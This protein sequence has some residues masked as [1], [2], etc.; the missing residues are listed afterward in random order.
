MAKSPPKKHTPPKTG[1]AGE[2]IV[3]D[4]LRK[5]GAKK[6]RV[7]TKQPGATD[8][9]AETPAGRKRI[10]VKT[11]VTPNKPKEPSTQEK[12]EIKKAAKQEGATAE[13]AKVTVNKNLQKVKVKRRKLD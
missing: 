2:Q 13:I 5:Q 6:I 3:A 11:A 10:Q 12:K 1:K 7:D 9:T 4:E 8:I